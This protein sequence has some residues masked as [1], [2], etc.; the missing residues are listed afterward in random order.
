[1]LYRGADK[2]LARSERTQATFPAFYGTWEVHYHVHKSPTLVPALA[3]S[4]H[5][6]AHYKFDRRDLFLS[7]SG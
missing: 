7:W 2:S 3:K 4:I 5:S 1:M 6:S